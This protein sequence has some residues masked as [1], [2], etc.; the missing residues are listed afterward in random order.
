MNAKHNLTREQNTYLARRDMADYI[1]NSLKLEGNAVSM[2]ETETILNGNNVGRVNLDVLQTILNLRRAWNFVLSNLDAKFDAAFICKVNSRVFDDE[3]LA[4]GKIRAARRKKSDEGYIPPEMEEEE[5]EAEIRRMFESKSSATERAV[6]FFLWGC[7][8]KLFEGGNRRT[9]M[10]CANKILMEAG[11]GILTIGDAHLPEFMERRAR[12]Y[13]TD[14]ISV[15]DQ[16]LRENCVQ[17]L[18]F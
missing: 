14:D 12:Y 5:V 3:N 9:N 18:T 13:E 7:K 17:G 8:V 15:I 6:T 2:A 4:W 16:W 10:L 1:Y 11:E